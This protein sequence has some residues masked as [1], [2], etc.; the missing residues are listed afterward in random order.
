MFTFSSLKRPFLFVFAVFLLLQLSACGSPEENSP[1]KV[2]NELDTHEQDPISYEMISFFKD[3]ESKSDLE[4]M[5]IKGHVVSM[6]ELDVLK[7]RETTSNF[8]ELGNL[9]NQTTLF[10]NGRTYTE[11]DGETEAW[12]FDDQ[13]LPLSCK[14]YY[15]GEL[16]H[17]YT[18]SYDFL[19]RKKTTSYF[20]SDQS[21]LSKTVKAYDSIGNLTSSI[22]ENI[23]G[24]RTREV[25]EYNDQNLKVIEL[26]IDDNQGDTL[27]QLTYAYEYDAEQNWIKRVVI[28]SSD[29]ATFLRTY[30]YK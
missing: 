23:M 2:S 17:S 8:D 13:G 28:S 7:Q 24:S 9:T 6:T 26:R 4:V 11:K 29:T 5:G 19:A 30:R 3:L 25:V 21:F 16:A 12:E 20:A 27:V 15:L 1:P 10:N 14:V 18:Y 22:E